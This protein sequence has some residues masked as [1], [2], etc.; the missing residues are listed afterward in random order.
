MNELVAQTLNCLPQQPFFPS[1]LVTEQQ[2]FAGT[3]L[4][5]QFEIFLVLATMRNFLFFR[6]WVLFKPSE[7]AGF[8]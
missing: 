5:M 4:F 1:L 6:L 8:L 3:F 7:L 2:Y